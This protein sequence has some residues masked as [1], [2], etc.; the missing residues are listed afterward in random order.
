MSTKLSEL[1]CT[2]LS[3]DIIGNIGA[4]ANAVELLEEGDMD[5]MEDIKSILKTSSGVLAARL[6]FF[7]MVFGIENGNLQNLQQVREITAAYISTV[8]GKIPPS[9]QFSLEDTRYAKAAMLAVMIAADMLIKGGTVCVRQLQNGVEISV[10]AEDRVSDDK[11]RNIAALVQGTGG[12]TT[13]QEAPLFSLM[14]HCREKG[15]KLGLA[16]APSL[17][18][19]L[20]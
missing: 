12:E 11:T 19:V 7:R 5:F 16:L 17:R 20:E 6:K 14:E 1:I 9:L 8:G 15:I 18:I 4:V 13:A 10:A 2:R 3:H